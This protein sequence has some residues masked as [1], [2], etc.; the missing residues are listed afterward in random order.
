MSTEDPSEY[1]SAQGVSAY[2][3]FGLLFASLAITAAVLVF[4][5][6]E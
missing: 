1:S 5:I 4:A 6:A 2:A 3:K